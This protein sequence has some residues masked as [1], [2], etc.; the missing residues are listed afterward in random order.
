MARP[1]LQCADEKEGRGVKRRVG[2]KS[3]DAHAGIRVF[4]DVPQ[5]HAY[6]KNFSLLRVSVFSKSVLARVLT[7]SYF[8]RVRM[9]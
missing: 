3:N 9:S 8:L 5:F 1:G 6:R 2:Q 7:S 4:R